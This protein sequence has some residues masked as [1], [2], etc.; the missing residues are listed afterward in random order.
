MYYAPNFKSEP[1]PLRL[2]RDSSAGRGMHG[3]GIAAMGAGCC[4][5]RD[6]SQMHTR[7]KRRDMRQLCHCKLPLQNDI[8]TSDVVQSVDASPDPGI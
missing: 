1:T 3:C 5:P 6:I 4:E 2:S 8:N 7:P